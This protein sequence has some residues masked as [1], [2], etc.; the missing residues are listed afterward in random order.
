MNR[1]DIR[2]NTLM[3]TLSILTLGLM[4]PLVAQEPTKKEAEKE[5]APVARKKEQ[6]PQ[7]NQ[8]PQVSMLTLAARLVDPENK[9][10]QKAAT[11]EV[12][13]SGLELIDPAQTGESAKAGQGH[14]HY[15]VDD[16]PVIATTTTKLSFHGLSS[17]PHKIVVML[18]G[19]DHKPLGPSRTLNV[20]IP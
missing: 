13:V 1:S 7:T 12:S 6:A 15:Q 17:G 9:A 18:A 11:V 10:K 4:A 16:G 19:N 3:L 5:A 2:I 20:T 8:P 14:I